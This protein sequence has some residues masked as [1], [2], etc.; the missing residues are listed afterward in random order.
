MN[1]VL[2]SIQIFKEKGAPGTVLSEA[3]AMGGH[4]LSGDRHCMDEFKPI[5]L[6]DAALSGWNDSQEYDAL[7]FH[8][9]KTNLTIEGLGELSLSQGDLIRIGEQTVLEISSAFKKCYREQCELYNHGI[10]CPLPHGMLFAACRAGGV[11]REGDTV[12]RIS[13]K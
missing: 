8:R 7:C 3:E 13:L 1:S 2:Q 12:T 9:F 10:P 4:G 6:S 5:S 11:I